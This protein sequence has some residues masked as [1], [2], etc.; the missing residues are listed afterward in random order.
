VVRLGAVAA[1][2]SMLAEHP[3][4]AWLGERLPGFGDRRNLVGV[5]E[6]LADAGVEQLRQFVSSS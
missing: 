6:A 2:Q 5:G 3:Q 4:I 1:E